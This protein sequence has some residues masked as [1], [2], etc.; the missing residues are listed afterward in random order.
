MPALRNIT[1]LN[2]WWI[3]HT[4]WGGCVFHVEM[5]WKDVTSPEQYVDS[6]FKKYKQ[7]PFEDIL[8]FSESDVTDNS[9]PNREIME[10]ASKIYMLRDSIRNNN[11][12]FLPQIIHEPW[13]ERYRIHP[14]SGRAAAKI[15]RAHV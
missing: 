9:M 10:D 12:Q 15:G 14:G 3:N 11:M 6:L 2:N 13:R 4:R 8:A 5:Q 1:T 7:L